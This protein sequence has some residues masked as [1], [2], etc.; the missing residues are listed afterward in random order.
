MRK[1]Q[2]WIGKNDDQ[3]V[4]DR[5]R[6]RVLERFGNRCDPREGSGG[7]GRPIRSG[8]RWTCDHKIAIIN[9]GAN[10]E[11]NLR[12]LCSWCDPSKTASDV[13][14]KSKTYERKA[15]DFGLKKT[16]HPI[17]GWKDFQGRPVRNPKLRRRA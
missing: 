3:P 2:E 10:R 15:K 9:G 4:P 16:R 1:L 14:E 6:L 17:S 11:N 7:C 13:A 8:E 12:P 5:V